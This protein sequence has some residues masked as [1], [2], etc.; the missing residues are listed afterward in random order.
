MLPRDEK[1]RDGLVWSNLKALPPSLADD[2]AGRNLRTAA[3]P[4]THSASK[5]DTT[6]YDRWNDRM[7]STIDVTMKMAERRRDDGD[8]ISAAA[9][10]ATAMLGRTAMAQ[11]D[12]AAVAVLSVQP[13]RI[14][15]VLQRRGGSQRQ[16]GRA[17]RY[18][19]YLVVVASLQKMYSDL[20]E[21]HYVQGAF[22]AGLFTFHHAA[23][24]RKTPAVIG[25]RRPQW[26]L[27]LLAKIAVAKKRPA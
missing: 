11:D 26:W 13:G 19:A 25:A 1:Q 14:L 20:E 10:V 27:G 24:P 21:E 18:E 9:N 17:L 4:P 7:R 2:G 8:E 23:H 3:Y 16:G 12:D 22:H 15:P 6:R 5:T